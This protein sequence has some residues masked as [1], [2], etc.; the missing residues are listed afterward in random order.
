MAKR[1]GKVA[2]TQKEKDVRRNKERRRAS[3][4]KH[5]EKYREL[6]NKK[7]RDKD[8][9]LK[10]ENPVK[11]WYQQVKQDAHKRGHEFNL[12]IEDFALP[13][14]CPILGIPLQFHF[15][16][17][18]YPDTPSMDRVDNLV[19]YLKGNV[20]VISWKANRYKSNMSKETVRNILEYMEGKR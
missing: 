7:S 1:L 14:K 17:K 5:R 4:K 2:L 6:I 20:R 15:D 16:S 3:R 10:L 18:I 12:T 9:R 8:R 19:G 13:E 11:N